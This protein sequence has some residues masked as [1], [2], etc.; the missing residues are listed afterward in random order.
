MLAENGLTG[1]I[2]PEIGRLA[3]LQQLLV[4]DNHLTGSIPPELGQLGDLRE[5]SIHST[6]LSG[7]L[8]LSLSDVPLSYFLYYDTQLCV[9]ADAGFRAWLQTIQTHRGTGR[10]CGN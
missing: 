7:P 8:P 9:P 3:N 4:E 6:E 1:P 2:P 5:L 10:D